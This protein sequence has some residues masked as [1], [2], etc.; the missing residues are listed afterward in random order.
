MN[1]KLTEVNVVDQERFPQ[2]LSVKSVFVRG[3]TVRY[4]Q[5]PREHVDTDLLQDACR[6]E[7]ESGA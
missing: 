4:V 2:L 6:K 5:I 3:S 7:M 1:I